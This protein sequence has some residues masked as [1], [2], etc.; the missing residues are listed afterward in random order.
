[1]YSGSFI[2]GKSHGEG[3]YVDR[4]TKTS[5]KGKWEQ[6]QLVSGTIDS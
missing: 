6:G 1:M 4:I 3:N 2:D 5:Y